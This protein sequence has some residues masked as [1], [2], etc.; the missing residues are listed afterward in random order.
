[1]IGWTLAGIM[2]LVVVALALLVVLDWREERRRTTRPVQDYSDVQ[3]LLE[4][5]G[6]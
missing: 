4:R 3:A 1:M 6:L 5:S 2:G